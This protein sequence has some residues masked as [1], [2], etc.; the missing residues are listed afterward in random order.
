VL[1][2]ALGLLLDDRIDIRETQFLVL[3][4]RDE[5]NR[6]TSMQLVRD[7]KDEILKRIPTDGTAGDQSFLAYVFTEIC[8]AEQ[9]DEIADYVTKMFA[10]LPGGERTVKQAIEEMDQCIARRTLVEPEIRR[11]LGGPSATTRTR[12]RW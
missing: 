3:R 12:S 8:R 2:T 7:H 10:G 1:D 6:R 4:A 9:R 5:I 11:W